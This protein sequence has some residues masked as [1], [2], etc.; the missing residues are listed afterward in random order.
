MCLTN[1]NFSGFLEGSISHVFAPN[2]TTPSYIEVSKTAK[3]KI[4]IIYSN[5]ISGSPIVNSFF[6]VLFWDIT[7]DVYVAFASIDFRNSNGPT[8]PNA[9]IYGVY[10]LQSGHQYDVWLQTPQNDSRFT[11]IYQLSINIEEFVTL[12]A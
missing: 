7:D 8:L 4:H 5:L 3:Y 12:Y 10:N 9:V 1:A 6:N 2:L 11:Q